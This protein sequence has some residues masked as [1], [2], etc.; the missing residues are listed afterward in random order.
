MDKHLK[1]DPVSSDFKRPQNVTN[2]HAPLGRSD[3]HDHFIEAVSP[4]YVT[5]NERAFLAP[6]PDSYDRSPIRI[7]RT[8]EESVGS[9]LN[10]N[11]SKI[12]RR[13]SSRPSFETPTKDKE[14][15]QLKESLTQTH[16]NQLWNDLQ[17]I[18]NELALNG[19]DRSI[20]TAVMP[21]ARNRLLDSGLEYAYGHMKARLNSSD[22]TLDKRLDNGE[23]IRSLCK[24]FIE[25]VEEIK[26][27]N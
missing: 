5:E 13:P 4:A 12:E 16:N 22:D 1:H 15:R 7:K 27:L 19:Y 2:P 3:H 18:L 17:S 21:V 20:A 25:C 24:T 26:G 14:K 6:S 10:W 9:P 8:A 23:T 11:S